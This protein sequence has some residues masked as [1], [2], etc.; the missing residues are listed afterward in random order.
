MGMTQLTIEQATGQLDGLIDAAVG[1]EE[2]V[3]QG[4]HGA[5]RLVPVIGSDAPR[6]LPP[7][8]WL[9]GKFELPDSFF[10]PLPDDLLDLFEGGGLNL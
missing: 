8:G 3:L 5:V 10:E 9:K 2:V 4:E 1:G 6:P 7:I